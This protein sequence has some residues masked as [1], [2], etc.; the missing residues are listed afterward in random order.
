ML[1]PIPTPAAI[2]W[3]TT[4]LQQ[5]IS[6]TD[7]AMVGSIAY[8]PRCTVGPLVDRCFRFQDPIT[9]IDI[10]VGQ[11]LVIIFEGL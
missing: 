6:A 7:D 4:L 5:H 1:L 8:G 11:A 2:G 9:L 10:P 3:R